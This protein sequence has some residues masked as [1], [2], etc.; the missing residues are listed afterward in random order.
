MWKG[1]VNT[2]TAAFEQLPL[3]YATG[4]ETT[5]KRGAK[6]SSARGSSVGMQLTTEFA[7]RRTAVP[8]SRIGLADKLVLLVVVALVA[9]WTL[10]VGGL[11]YQLFTRV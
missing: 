10:A 1:R 11:V 2:M 9:G 6:P 4:A 5:Q 7:E 3:S 8:P